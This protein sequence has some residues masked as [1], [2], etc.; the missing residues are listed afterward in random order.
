MGSEHFPIPSAFFHDHGPV[1]TERKGLAALVHHGIF[2]VTG[3]H[4]NVSQKQGRLRVQLR[5][6]AAIT[7]HFLAGQVPLFA[8]CVKIGK[9]A[10]SERDIGK[11]RVRMGTQRFY[12]V[13]CHR[14][15]KY[16]LYGSQFLA[17]GFVQICFL[18]F[19]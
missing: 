3:T 15:F 6:K 4:G 17:F 14:L 1:G 5:G 13:A 19:L 2:R 10:I 9:A 16:D 7:H 18:R 8:E 11:L 12:I